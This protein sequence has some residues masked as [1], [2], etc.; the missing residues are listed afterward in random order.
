MWYWDFIRPFPHQADL[1]G[2]VR[3]ARGLRAPASTA[4]GIDRVGKL[5]PALTRQPD[6]E[7]GKVGD[8]ALCT[9][10]LKARLTL[11]LKLC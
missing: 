4:L 9:D 10:S 8:L 11:S 3:H 6:R 2:L 7:R 1:S 5:S